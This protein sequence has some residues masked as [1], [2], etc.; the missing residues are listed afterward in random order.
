MPIAQCPFNT[1][2]IL[3][4]KCLRLIYIASIFHS[5]T[6]VATHACALTNGEKTHINAVHSSQ[7]LYFHTSPTCHS[8]L[9]GKAHTRPSAST[10]INFILL[11][12]IF[13]FSEL[14]ENLPSSSLLRSKL[15]VEE[16]GLETS[17]LPMKSQEDADAV[18]IMRSLDTV[19]EQQSSSTLVKN[20]SSARY[21]GA[22]GPSF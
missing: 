14:P 16:A 21:H 10:F 1:S 18:P 19:E 8:F 3:L 11:L 20:W 13:R 6:L 12:S 22:W 4:Y 17:D 7:T 2:S 15:V 5:Y 9:S